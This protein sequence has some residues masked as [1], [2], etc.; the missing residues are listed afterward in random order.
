MVGRV[1][2][3]VPLRGLK[4]PGK[5]QREQAQEKSLLCDTHQDHEMYMVTGLQVQNGKG[6]KLLFWVWQVEKNCAGH[7]E[8]G[9]GTE[10]NTRKWLALSTSDLK[11]GSSSIPPVSPRGKEASNSIWL[12]YCSAVFSRSID[13]I[14]ITWM[15]MGDVKISHSAWFF[16]FHSSIESD[17]QKGTYPEGQKETACK[18]QVRCL[19]NCLQKTAT[20]FLKAYLRKK[21][22]MTSTSR[23]SKTLNAAGRE[24]VFQCLL[25]KN[26]HWNYHTSNIRITI[27]EK[28]YLY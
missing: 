3:Q 4:R 24:H 18:H 13:Q 2:L 23:T 19:Y 6:V 1:T 27:L 7:K 11:T 17:Y 16:K 28:L 8:S 26:P 21:W 9:V 10:R 12:A 14:N 15:N 20:S 22:Y 5:W 25:P